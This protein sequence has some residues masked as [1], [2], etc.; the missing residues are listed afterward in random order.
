[1]VIRFLGTNVVVVAAFLSLFATGGSMASAS[2]IVGFDFE[3]A[4]N[5]DS[6]AAA[7]AVAGGVSGA[8]FGGSKS[9]SAVLL[10]GGPD[11]IYR[12]AALDPNNSGGFFNF[13]S[14]TTK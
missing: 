1:M 3:N 2:T 13:F 8:V 11:L 7:S 6:T 10:A 14:F 5:G 12:S 4:T 9:D